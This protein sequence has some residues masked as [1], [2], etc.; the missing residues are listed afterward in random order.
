MSL[1]GPRRFEPPNRK[2]EGWR[3]VY[4]QFDLKALAFAVQP[5]LPHLK[6]EGKN[7][8]AGNG[9]PKD[10]GTMQPGTVMLS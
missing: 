5:P 10:N 2:W 7:S 8:E 6:Q 4:A 1:N 3:T 9:L